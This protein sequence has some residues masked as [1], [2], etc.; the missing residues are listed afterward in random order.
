MAAFKVVQKDEAF[1]KK[2]MLTELKKEL[3]DAKQRLVDFL[4]VDP[5]AETNKEQMQDEKDKKEENE[6]KEEKKGMPSALRRHASNLHAKTKNLF[7]KMS[8]NTEGEDE[9]G[10]GEEAVEQEQEVAN[11]PVRVSYRSEKAKEKK[12]KALEAAQKQDILHFEE[13]QS[14]LEDKQFFEKL[15]KAQLRVDQV[16]NVFQKLDI[17]GKNQVRVQDF[18][19][20]LLRLKQRVQGIDVAAGKSWMRRLVLESHGLAYTASTMQQ[21]TLAIVE[22]LRGVQVLEPEATGEGEGE[23]RA[24][25]KQRATKQAEQQLIE[26]TNIRMR[27]K[28][29]KVKAEVER[30]RARLQRL[31]A[32]D[33]YLTLDSPH[34]GC[35]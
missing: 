30:R 6:E 31:H 19:E 28:I 3:L 24:A 33:A 2:Q 34:P 29:A 8:A 7:A 20:G 25:D 23:P 1:R 18:V 15:Q 11:D 35:D 4:D 26:Q 5:E 10:K 27:K 22:Q 12:S 17:G 16:L 14:L 32:Y 9:N 13:L 21:T